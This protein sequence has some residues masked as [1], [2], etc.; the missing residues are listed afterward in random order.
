MPRVSQVLGTKALYLLR[1]FILT[2]LQIQDYCSAAT[3]WHAGLQSTCCPNLKKLT[4]LANFITN[5][6]SSL[7]S[8][9][10]PSLLRSLYDMSTWKGMFL[11]FLFPCL[12]FSNTSYPFLDHD[13]STIQA[14]SHFSGLHGK[15]WSARYRQPCKVIFQKKTH[16]CTV[17]MQTPSYSTTN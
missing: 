12:L 15:L 3:R 2:T 13:E 6:Y 16:L 9:S 17:C 4:L 11:Y 5:S 10:Y 8:N 7:L 1:P 14:Q